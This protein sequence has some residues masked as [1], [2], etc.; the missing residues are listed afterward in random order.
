VWIGSIS[1]EKD[2]AL[3]LDAFAQAGV[4]DARLTFVGDG[5]LRSELE[6]RAVPGVAFV[7]SVPDVGPYL[8]AA[9]GL[10]L[11]SKTEG[12][13]GVVL[14]ALAAG[15]PVIATDVGGVAD[16][17]VEGRTGFLVRSGDLDGMVDAVRR[18]GRDPGGRARMGTAGRELVAGG[19][20]LTHS[21]DRYDAALRR[22]VKGTTP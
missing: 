6:A 5:P 2:P 3:A 21:V 22:V 8:Q 17:V 15:V 20:L 1:A 10:V 14:E 19:Y 11:S 18:L 9:G 12:L 4:G 7:G 13:P 16:L